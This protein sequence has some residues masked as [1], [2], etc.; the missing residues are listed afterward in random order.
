MEAQQVQDSDTAQA[1]TAAGDTARSVIENVAQV[2][3]APEGLIERCVLALL[4]EGHIIL[5]DFPGVGK[6][7][8]AKSLARSLDC[9]FARI[10]ATPDLLPS[11]ITGVNVYN[12]QPA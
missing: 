8:L 4:C 12:L 10:Q 2:I 11:D 6:T 9:E 7:M 5:E 1:I 3:H